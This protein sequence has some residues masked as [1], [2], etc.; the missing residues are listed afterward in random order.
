MKIL[1]DF[2]KQFNWIDIFILILFLRIAYISLKTGLP[3]EFF[4]ILGTLSAVYLSLHY[5]TS[6]ANF[7]AQRLVSKN[8]PLPI[9]EFFF[10]IALAFIGYGLFILLRL[11]LCRC[12]SAEVIP[13]LSKWGG[14]IVGLTRGFLLASLVLF[15]FFKSQVTYFKKSINDSFSGNYIV[16][17]APATYSWFWYKIISKFKTNEKFNMSVLEINTKQTK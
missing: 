7:F 17:V 8:K 2:L 9:L 16:N 1:L 13:N 3:A 5:Y 10:F 14:L 15:I 6:F 4:K 11:L 12:V